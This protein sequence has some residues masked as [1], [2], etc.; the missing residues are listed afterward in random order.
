M[1]QG[2]NPD[3][4]RELMNGEIDGTNDEAQSSELA[5]TLTGNPKAREEFEALQSLS[6]RLDAVQDVDPPAHLIHRIISAIPFGR[7]DAVAKADTGGGIGSWL[8]ALFP[9]PSLRYASAFAVGLIAGFALLWAALA[10]DRVDGSLD[11]SNLY[12]TMRA[13]NTSDGFEVV[14][15]VGIDTDQVH[16]EVRLHES[17]RKLLA[18][19]L[20]NPADQ[21]EWVLRY[22]AA[23][24]AF[25]GFRQL[26]G[27][28]GELTAKGD[29]MRVSQAGSG[30]YIL[31]FTETNGGPAPMSIEIFAGSKLLFNKE[32]GV[33][34]G[35]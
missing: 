12:G 21:I 2:S 8:A 27:R 16:G 22:D 17:D 30:R 23:E 4:L 32:L 14:G 1:T 33:S 3:R 11:I 20:L 5:E 10:N 25:E 34:S 19:I 26:E 24:V 9:R 7:Y 29:E 13:I 31:L 6:R 15:S 28:S 18:E 35:Q